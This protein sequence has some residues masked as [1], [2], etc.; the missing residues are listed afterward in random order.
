MENHPHLNIRKKL[1]IWYPYFHDGF[2]NQL[3]DRLPEGT[4]I[5]PWRIPQVTVDRASRVLTRK[6]DTKKDKNAGFPTWEVSPFKL[7]G[8]CT[9]QQNKTKKTRLPKMLANGWK[10]IMK[11]PQHTSPKKRNNVS[12]CCVNLIKSSPVL[13]PPI[14]DLCI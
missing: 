2:S 11:P 13:F 3:C 4:S 6:F 9:L 10:A 5:Y 12:N 7:K 8:F 1:G 14:L